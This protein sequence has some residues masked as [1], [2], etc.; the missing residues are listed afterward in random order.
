MRKRKTKQNERRRINR[1][2]E[3]TTIK[4]KQYPTREK[5]EK[6]QDSNKSHARR[7]NL[8]EASTPASMG[9]VIIVD[10]WFYTKISVLRKSLS[11]TYSFIL[12]HNSLFIYVIKGYSYCQFDESTELRKRILEQIGVCY[13]LYLNSW[14]SHTHFGTR[15]DYKGKWTPWTILFNITNRIMN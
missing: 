13:Q 1:W 10:G 9:N 4:S 11:I 6:I 15:D 14:Y 8:N 3:E 7:L 2:I 12:Y 5:K